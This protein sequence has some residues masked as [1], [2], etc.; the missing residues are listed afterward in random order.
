MFILIVFVS[1]VS[2]SLLLFPVIFHAFTI[3]VY[4]CHCLSQ[5]IMPCHYEAFFLIIQ[6]LLSYMFYLSKKFS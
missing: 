4:F 2:Q 6:L 3:L 5:K 1:A